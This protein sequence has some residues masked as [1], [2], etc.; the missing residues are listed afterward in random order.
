MS[1]SG[2]SLKDLH[3]LFEQSTTDLGGMLPIRKTSVGVW[4]PTPVPVI[5]KAAELLEEMGLLGKLAPAGLV[6]DAGTGD[7]RV[8]AVLASLDPM[9]LICGIEAD[10]VFYARAVT[11]VQVLEKRG[12]ACGWIALVEGDYCDTRTYASHRLDLRGARMFLN[13]PDGNERELARFI[14]EQAGAATMLCLLTHDRSI[15]VD[16]LTRRER[17][18]VSLADEQDWFLSLYQGAR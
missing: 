2:P 12:S 3:E 5:A 15:E 16:D 4:V 8:P 11:N 10:A 9:C 14:A 7:G 6:V 17:L 18:R 13:Y 1:F